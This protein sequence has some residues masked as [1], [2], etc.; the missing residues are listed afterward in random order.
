MGTA[1]RPV[2]IDNEGQQN[3]NISVEKAAMGAVDVEAK[4]TVYVVLACAIA[5]S[6]GVLFGY[7]GEDTPFSCT[8]SN[9]LRT[10]DAA[11]SHLAMMLRPSQYTALQGVALTSY[12]SPPFTSYI[13]TIFL[14][15]GGITGGVES[16]QQFAEMW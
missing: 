3:G 8:A 14:P 5:A 13:N 6:G 12:L 2:Q 16:M 10:L 1:E 7:D 4:V 9:G 11:A 15:A